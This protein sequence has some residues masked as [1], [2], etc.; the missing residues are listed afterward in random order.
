MYIFFA[1]Y[2]LLLFLKI[3]LFTILIM[4]IVQFC[5]SFSKIDNKKELQGTYFPKIEQF[6]NNMAD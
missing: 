4:K 1:Y 6:P 5:S 3:T 2:T